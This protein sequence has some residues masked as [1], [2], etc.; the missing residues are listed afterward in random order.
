[1][2]AEALHGPKVIPCR[3]TA[4]EEDTY[5]LYRLYQR[6]FDEALHTMRLMRRYRRPEVRYCLLR[7]A[8]IAY[9]RPFSGNRGHVH[10]RHKLPLR[11]VPRGSRSIHDDLVRRRHGLIAHTDIKERRPQI[12]RWP[13]RG[14]FV[15]LLGVAHGDWGSLDRKIGAVQALV[16][17]VTASLAIEIERLEAKT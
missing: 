16:E 11:F 7:D 4:A 10:N 15:Y 1:V 6:D 5:T 3:L 2:T 12:A 14:R 9:C 13:A 17:A 8:V